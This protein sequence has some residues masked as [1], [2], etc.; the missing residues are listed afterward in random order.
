MYNIDF[1]NLKK[2]Y[3]FGLIFAIAGLLFFLVFFYI[4]FGGFIKKQTM[5]SEIVATKIEEKCDEEGMCSPIYY[6]EVDN[7]TYTCS[8]TGS[9]N[10]DVKSEENKV[11][12][13]SKDPSDCINEYQ[14]TIRVTFV[15][16]SLFPLLFLGVGIYEIMRVN[17]RVK[18]AKYLAEHGTLFQGIPYTMEPSGYVINGR[19][20]MTITID[21]TL[22]NGTTLHLIGPPRHDNM[23]SDADRLV[24][25]LIDL[26]DP[27]NYYIDFAITRKTDI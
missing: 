26:N 25:L 19:T 9:T 3:S 18:K 6:Y 17:K 21:Y 15:L 4:A 27:D 13:N 10:I 5:D 24:D 11:F 16:I 14:A 20:L 22:P 7:Q 12:Y 2:G 1:K 23:T 8:T